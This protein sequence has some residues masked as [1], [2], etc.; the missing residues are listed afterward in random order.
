MKTR[1]LATPASAHHHPPEGHPERAERYQAVL[2]GAEASSVEIEQWTAPVDRI[3]LERVHAPA[4]VDAIMA[5]SPTRGEV[6]LDAD[7]YV[8]TGSLGATLAAAGAGIAAVDQVLDG[9]AEAVFVACRP[10]GHHAEPDRSMGFCLFNT[11]AIAAMHAIEERG[12]ASAAIVDVD[13]H[14]G[15][16]T[17]AFVEDE[18]RLNF[19]SL[20]QEWIYP[21]TGA[22]HE[23]GARG[24]I[25]NIPLEAGTQGE[26]WLE[27]F[28][29]QVLP[30]LESKRPDM[31]LVSAGFDAHRADPLAGLALDEAD[32]AAI[33]ARL[34]QAA[35]AFSHSRLVCVLEG[36]YDCAALERCVGAFLGALKAG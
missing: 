33:G 23:T 27:R 31:L 15:N 14:H 26:A 25:L 7:T 18:P 36:G 32:Y 2:A 8:S 21:G 5:A 11:V 24:N 17:Q 13:V 30:L 1:V 34:A 9:E 12:L 20:H 29:H 19:V 16:G 6:A 35:R 10:P 28:E 4:L 22:A 3:A